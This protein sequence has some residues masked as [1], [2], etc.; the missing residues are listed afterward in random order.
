MQN[1]S[2]YIEPSG[3]EQVYSFE[4]AKILI[5]SCTEI[6][7][8]FKIMCKEIT[9]NIVSGDMGSYKK[10]IMSRYPKITKAEVNINR[11]GRNLC[12]FQE[13]ESGKLS[14]WEAYQVVK[15]DRGARFS[16]AT[17]INAVTALSALYILILYLA[18]ITNIDFSNTPS[19]YIS[20][21]YEN[22]Y[23][24]CSPSVNLPD[25]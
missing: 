13:W 18:Q 8:V 17:Y 19:S 9:G 1:T 24:L 14:W 7:S 5:L 15:H 11:L 22:V 12:P 4:F 3:Q 25:F 2:Q 20:S 6:E 21:Q 10:T 23:L 16:D